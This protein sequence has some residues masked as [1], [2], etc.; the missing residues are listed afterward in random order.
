MRPKKDQSS[1]HHPTGMQ[2][3]EMF[4]NL[5]PPPRATL[6]P[7]IETFARKLFR[8]FGIATAR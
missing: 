8:V 6:C 2:G 7:E 3:T 1:T 5:P 4:G